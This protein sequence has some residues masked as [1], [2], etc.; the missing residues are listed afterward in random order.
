[1]LTYDRKAF[2]TPSF[3]NAGFIPQFEFGQG[4]SYTTFT[5]SDL[6]LSAKTISRS[7]NISVTVTVTNTGARAGKEVVQLYL[8]DLVASLSPPGKRL[9][10]FAKI[11]L[12]P[13]KS[14]AL[15]FNLRQEDLSFIGINNKPVVE[16]GDFEVT[17]GGLKEKFTV[18]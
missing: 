14:R 6:R 9:K 13:G 15:N 17:I 10:R 11:Y 4:L 12:E 8:T 7:E 18:K 16:P 2:E 1:L 3:D 5:H